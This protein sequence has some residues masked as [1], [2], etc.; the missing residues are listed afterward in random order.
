MLVTHMFNVLTLHFQSQV[1]WSWHDQLFF[2]FFF[3]TLAHRIH[4]TVHYTVFLTVVEY[5]VAKHQKTQVRLSKLWSAVIELTPL[6]A[7][8]AVLDHFSSLSSEQPLDYESKRAYTLK[9]EATNIRSEPSSGGP[10]KDTATVK[11]VV[12]DSDE[13]PVFSKPMY[14]LE[15]NENAPI[16][17]VIGTVTARDPDTSGSLVRY[18]RV[19]AVDG[20]PLALCYGLTRA[21]Q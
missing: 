20:V 15:V 2:F 7:S 6:F 1:N 3:F 14:L 12:E 21:M 18:E 4:Y 13:P 11:V 19:G 16:N 9:V 5:K 17:T 10:F 8:V